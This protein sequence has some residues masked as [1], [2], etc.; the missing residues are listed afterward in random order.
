MKGI[1][2]IVPC[3]NCGKFIDEC[4]ESILNF[5]IKNKYEIIVVDDCSKDE[6]QNILK[7][8]ENKKN[9]QIYRNEENKGVQYSRNYGLKKAKFDYVMTIDGDDK[10]NTKLS[11]RKKGY[12]DEAIDVLENNENIAFVQGIWQMFGDFSGYTITT[13]PVTEELIVHKHHVQTS[14]IH[15]RSDNVFY[16]EEIKKF[17]DWSF[18]VTL[19]NK[20]YLEGK[21]N[22]IYFIE[23]PY[24]LY[25]IH[26][27]KNRISTNNTI[28]EY[29]MLKITVRKN[30]DI[31]K[32][33]FKYYDLETIYK[34]VYKS[35]PNKFVSMLYVANYSM[36]IAIKM[37]NER[38]YDIKAT[39]DPPMFSC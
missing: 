34:K 18:G 32:K 4:I 17:Q 22:D 12:I 5:N 33:Y 30:Q 7:K 2:I 10:L 21:K 28:S 13:Y 15:R 6:T 9:V 24:Y 29:E 14:I 31:F 27:S 36:K 19:I 25:R 35:I 8:Y 3:Y 11:E 26:N 37:K 39:I 23:Q 38:G 20:R 16:D 1:S